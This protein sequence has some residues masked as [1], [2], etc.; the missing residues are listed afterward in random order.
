M[1]E[2]LAPG[3]PGKFGIFAVIARSMKHIDDLPLVPSGLITPTI[4]SSFMHMSDAKTTCRLTTI[5]LF[6]GVVRANVVSASSM[7][8]SITFQLAHGVAKS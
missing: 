1:P 8:V 7:I 4:W 2:I 6:A 5:N 3:E